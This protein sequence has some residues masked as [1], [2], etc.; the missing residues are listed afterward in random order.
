MNEH[1]NNALG[2]PPRIALVGCSWFARAAH[3]PALAR[4]SHEGLVEVAALCS[5]SQESLAEARKL[6]GAEVPT[7]LDFDEM[8]STASI[9][10]VDLVL[11]TPLMGTAIRKAFQA[12]R[13]VI[14]EKPCAS[15]LADCRELLD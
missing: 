8:L 5:R 15:S 4:L 10:A 9:D 14:S 13:H 6:I 11:P 7:W 12:G 2:R 1:L 3:L